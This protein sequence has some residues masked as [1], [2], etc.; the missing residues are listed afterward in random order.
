ML[1]E[2][3]GAVDPR[4]VEALKIAFSASAAPRS[5][6]HAP[7]REEEQEDFALVDV[8]SRSSS[9]STT[10]AATRSSPTWRSREGTRG[11]EPAIVEELKELVDSDE[12]LNHTFNKFRC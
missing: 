3:P 1:E 2:Q 10:A 8:H 5:R 7:L 4:D 9:R 6:P 12:T 11:L